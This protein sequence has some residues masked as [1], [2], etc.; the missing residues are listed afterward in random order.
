MSQEI[1]TI[2]ILYTYVIRPDHIVR[3]IS[4]PVDSMSLDTKKHSALSL[5]YAV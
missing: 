2:Q 5:R 1:L 4:N 3:F